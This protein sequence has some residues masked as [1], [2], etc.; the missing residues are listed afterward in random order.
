MPNILAT[1]ALNQDG[2]NIELFDTIKQ[3]T[4]KRFP[5]L[6]LFDGWGLSAQNLEG[7]ILRKVMLEG[8]EQDIVS[9]PVHDA[10]AVKQGDAEWAKEAMER[11]WGEETL[12]GKTRLKVDYPD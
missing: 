10:I 3:G 9:L 5:K 2:F 12:G 7:A 6:K 11:V 1:K 8:I 4:L